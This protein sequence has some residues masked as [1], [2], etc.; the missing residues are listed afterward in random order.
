MEFEDENSAEAERQHSN[1][2]RWMTC[3]FATFLLFCVVDC[4][5]AWTDFGQPLLQAREAST[6]NA[7]MFHLARFKINLA[8][9]PARSEGFFAIHGRREYGA[10]NAAIES[11]ITRLRSAENSQAA[12]SQVSTSQ[13]LALTSLS[14]ELAKYDKHIYGAHLRYSLGWSLV[15]LPAMG[16]I[17]SWGQTFER[18]ISAST[19][20][21]W[22]LLIIPWLLL[23]LLLLI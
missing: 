12:P 15:I 19:R 1:G 9:E 18:S 7:A 21:K 5:N 3:L 17:I 8:R 22:R 6:P 10:L 20:K 13:F 14:E 4:W 2:Q 16:A 11:T 23:P